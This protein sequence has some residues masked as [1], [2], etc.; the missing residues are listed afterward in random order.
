M[1]TFVVEPLDF[2]GIILTQ[3]DEILSGVVAAPPR[4][5]TERS[6]FPVL[7]RLPLPDTTPFLPASGTPTTL[8]GLYRL[9]EGTHPTPSVTVVVPVKSI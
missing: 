9:S 8:R 3:K 7:R 6:S 5:E 4:R 2:V 1:S